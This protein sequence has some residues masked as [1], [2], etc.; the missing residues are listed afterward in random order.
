MRFLIYYFIVILG[1]IYE[2]T[3][4]SSL[5]SHCIEIIFFQYVNSIKHELYVPLDVPKSEIKGLETKC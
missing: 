4:K 5:V 1:F 2:D 3:C